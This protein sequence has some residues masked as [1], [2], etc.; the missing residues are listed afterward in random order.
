M[1]LAGERREAAG[2]AQVIAQRELGSRKRHAIPSRAMRADIATGIE[3]HPR[4]AA[5][6]GL[7]VELIEAH[8]T[9]RERI[10]MRRVDAA[11]VARQMIAPELVAHDEQHVANVGHA[12][13]RPYSRRSF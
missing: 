9:C 3:R 10:E 12:G 11:A 5:D 13:D 1:L 2:A 4:R 8:A 6:A 7:D